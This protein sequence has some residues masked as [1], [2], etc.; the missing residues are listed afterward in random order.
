MIEKHPG[1]SCPSLSV[2]PERMSQ[3]CLPISYS[4][5]QVF[6]D[7]IIFYEPVVSFSVVSFLHL[8]IDNHIA[9][10]GVNPSESFFH[11][12]PQTLMSVYKQKHVGKTHFLSDEETRRPASESWQLPSNTH[13]APKFLSGQEP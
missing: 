6:V 7:L 11:S 5:L 4:P 8:K 10:K 12:T 13:S 2:F 1:H 9:E 3:S